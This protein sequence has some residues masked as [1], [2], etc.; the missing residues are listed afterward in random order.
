M[1]KKESAE[2]DRRKPKK[3]N[4][5]DQKKDTGKGKNLKEK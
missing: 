5:E 1:R 2:K 4:H 3:E